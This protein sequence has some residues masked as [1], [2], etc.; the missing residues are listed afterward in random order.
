[1]GQ[2]NWLN[3]W[4]AV[5]SCTFFLFLLR[6]STEL[7]QRL[8]GAT[9]YVGSRVCLELLKK[10]YTVHAPVRSIT[11]AAELKKLGEDKINLFEVSDIITVRPMLVPFDQRC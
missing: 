7:T 11:R 2:T 8:A 4:E 1:M 5:I 9:G 6:D 3:F 10:G